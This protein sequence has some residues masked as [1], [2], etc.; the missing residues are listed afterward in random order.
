[1]RVLVIG[2]HPDD[3]VLGAGGSL[4]R[5]AEE[6]HSLGVLLLTDNQQRHS[7]AIPLEQT[8]TAASEELAVFEMLQMA[9]MPD[10]GLHKLYSEVLE[11]IERAMSDFKPDLVISHTVHDLNLDHRTVAE[12]TLVACRPHRYGGGLLTYAV[13]GSN[14]GQPTGVQHDQMFVK[15]EHRHAR[16]KIAAYLKYKE[17]VV[18]SPNLRSPDLVMAQMKINGGKIHSNWAEAFGVVRWLI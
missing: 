4:A 16:K 11:K 15:L 13:A 17:E 7:G 5:W 3:E 9:R 18:M 2:A 14:F 1:M 12:A 10:Q 8:V 6:S